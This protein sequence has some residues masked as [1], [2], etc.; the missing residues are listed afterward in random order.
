MYIILTCAQ[1]AFVLE[2]RLL[3]VI[4]LEQYTDVNGRVIAYRVE[5]IPRRGGQNRERG[6]ML[7]LVTMLMGGV[8]VLWNKSRFSVWGGVLQAV[9]YTWLFSDTLQTLN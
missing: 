6:R 4:L 5:L 3:V 8:L 7:A 1:L 2:L 9:G